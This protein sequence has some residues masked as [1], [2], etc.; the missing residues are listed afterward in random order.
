[1]RLSFDG[2]E[3]FNEAV[4]SLRFNNPASDSNAGQQMGSSSSMSLQDFEGDEDNITPSDQNTLR[5]VGSSSSIQDSET[6]SL[7]SEDIQVCFNN[8]PSNPEYTS[9]NEM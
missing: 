1:M 8:F 6:G 7:R 4:E 9:A 2:V 3:S 5:R